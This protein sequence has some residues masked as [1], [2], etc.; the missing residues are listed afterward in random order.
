MAR[1][2]P[3]LDPDA[4]K[5]AYGSE[6]GFTLLEVLIAVAILGLSL[7]SLLGSQID[8]LRATRYAQGVT[9]AAFLAEYQLHEIEWLQREEGWQQSDANYDGDFSDQGW[10]D[11]TYECLVDFIELPEYNQMVEAK[12]DADEASGDDSSY[13]DAGDQAFS[14]MGMVWPIVK[15]AIENSIRK[16][17]CTVRWQDGKIE[18]EFEVQTFWTDAQRLKE[19]PALGGEF[20]ADDDDSGQGEEGSSGGSGGSSGGGGGTSFPGGKTGGGLGGG[21][22]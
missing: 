13:M 14:A 19:I 4:R 6:G 21:R 1:L 16:A 15:Q 7:T 5:V 8:S 3:E 20:S 12:T 2:D 10:P 9:A 18:H 22:G 11:I 17:S